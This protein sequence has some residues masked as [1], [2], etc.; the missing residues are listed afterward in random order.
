MAQ[1][2]TVLQGNGKAEVQGLCHFF[3]NQRGARAGGQCQEK[4]SVSTPWLVLFHSTV[5]D[6]PFF[7]SVNEPP[8]LHLLP[9]KFKCFVD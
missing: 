7:Y 6:H 3:I 5:D 1:P 8:Y 9:I 4:L 2:S